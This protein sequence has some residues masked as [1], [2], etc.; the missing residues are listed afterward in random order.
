MGT[1]L[2]QIRRAGLG[3]QLRGTWG[4]QRNEIEDQSTYEQKLYFQ[5]ARHL[6]QLKGWFDF[7]R[8]REQ[9]EVVITGKM[10]CFLSGFVH[11]LVESIE[12][13]LGEFEVK[14][15]LIL[16]FANIFFGRRIFICWGRFR[17]FVLWGQNLKRI[18]KK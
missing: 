7:W 1:D 11:I 3:L 16:L 5:I 14:L 15:I 10:F 12:D 2:V 6:Q 8:C 9:D 13:L 17:I 18:F 4:D